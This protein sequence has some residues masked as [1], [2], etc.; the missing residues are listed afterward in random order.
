MSENYNAEDSD[1][2]EE[3]RTKKKPKKTTDHLVQIYHKQ[4]QDSFTTGVLKFPDITKK[5]VVNTLRMWEG[6]YRDHSII[7]KVEMKQ[8]KRPTEATPKVNQDT[9]SNSNEPRTE[10]T[11]NQVENPN[12]QMMEINN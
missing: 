10:E 12:P 11:T 8:F 6:D 5:A 2:E 7:N 3:E 1:S 4:Q 9:S